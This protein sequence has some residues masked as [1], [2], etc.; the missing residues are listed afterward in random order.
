M[1]G[2]GSDRVYQYNLSTAWDITTCSFVTSILITTIEANPQEIFF[3]P[4]GTAFYVVGTTND[5]V[6]QY[7]L[8]TAWDLST[9]SYAS[10]SFAVG[11]QEANPSA[12]NFKPD[13]TRMWMSGNTNSIIYQYNLSTAWD[14]STASYAS[15]SY[16]PGNS[17]P[18]SLFFK[19]DGTA[20]WTLGASPVAIY[21]YTLS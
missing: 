15:I 11:A 3:K 6:Y 10:K 14:V 12:L 16:A 18:R 8:G 4:D 19:P 5:V 1:V 2:S 7:S 9:A 21:Q 17:S 20:M 13:G